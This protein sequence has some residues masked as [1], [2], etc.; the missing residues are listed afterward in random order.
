MGQSCVS[1]SVKSEVLHVKNGVSIYML[2]C[3]HTPKVSKIIEH[4]KT[5]KFKNTKK[6]KIFVISFLIIKI[7]IFEIQINPP[8]SDHILTVHCWQSPSVRFT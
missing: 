7:L 3:I 8:L 2:I 4:M 6:F 5:K 1:T